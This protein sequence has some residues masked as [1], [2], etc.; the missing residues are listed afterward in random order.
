MKTFLK[1]L[2]FNLSL[3]VIAVLTYSNGF[4]A[5][6]ITDPSIL[7]AGLS[8]LI[9]LGLAAGL[10]FGNYR[11]LKDPTGVTPAM[12]TDAKQVEAALKENTGSRYFGSLAR[13]AL[14]QFRRIGASTARALA[15]VHG[16]F[17]TGSM[18]ESRYAAAIE[19]AGQTAL[20]NMK[21]I[22]MRM[23]MF[24]DDEYR[25]LQSYRRD[26]IPDDIQTQQLA[27]YGQNLDYIKQ[28]VAA[29]EALILKLD[30]LALEISNAAGDG[31]AASDAL[32]AE[33]TQLTNELKYYQ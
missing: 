32:L 27:L 11:L 2:L 19:A 9:G 24:N 23:S 30:T 33:I 26:N 18:T 22:A 29:N 15:A 31:A 21:N 20:E 3:V 10:V 1:L 14:E 25:R 12:L 16:K 4:L 28:S 8:V 6:R 17:Q 7:R 5:L 13:T